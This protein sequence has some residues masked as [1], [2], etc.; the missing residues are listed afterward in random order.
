MDK[1]EFKQLVL[2]LN[3]LMYESKYIEYLELCEPTIDLG[4]ELHMFNDVLLIMR[5]VSECYYQLGHLDT[6]IEKLV[7]LKKMIDDYGTEEDYIYFLNLSYIYWDETG[8]KQYAGSFLYEA[9]PLARQGHYPVMLRKILNNLTAYHIMT[10]KYEEAEQYALET[11]M[12]LKEEFKGDKLLSPTDY[13]PPLIN[14]ALILERLNRLEEC[15]K[16]LERGFRYVPENRIIS[17]LN[18]LFTLS[19]VRRKQGRIDE[20][21]TI[22]LEAKS[23]AL[24][25]HSTT[26]SVEILTALI[27]LYKNR[28][29]MEALI[30]TQ[31][32]YIDVLER[33]QQQDLKTR[34]S[35]V[36]QLANLRLDYHTVLD[37]LTKVYNRKYFERYYYTHLKK[38]QHL[39]CFIDCM[40][41]K[42]YNAL[43]GQLCGNELLKTIANRAKGIFD[44]QQGIFARFYNDRF[45]GVIPVTSQ[46][47]AENWLV[48]LQQ[49][50]ADLPI[51]VRMTSIYF[52]K[53][54]TLL[55]PHLIEQATHMLKI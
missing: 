24:A 4:I 32:Q 35:K 43:H 33:A 19:E 52:E 44:E 15:E 26:N 39:F 9:L 3:E 23:L 2:T 45:Y 31:Q 27:A 40:N 54:D 48:Q 55:L 22:L 8:D 37:P 51:D 47:Q 41:F 30:E 25:H 1:E 46:Q 13:M 50:L 16:V 34:L 11:R 18:L 49:I 29:D 12:L 28:G 36:G 53:D 17:R 20:Q 21:H 5:Q 14:Y 38:G 7:P 10:G 6:A 42:Q